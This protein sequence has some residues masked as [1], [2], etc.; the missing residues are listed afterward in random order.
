MN[1][2]QQR[3][4]TALRRMGTGWLLPGSATAELSTLT[5]LHHSLQNTWHDGQWC[6][7]TLLKCLFV[8][9]WKAWFVFPRCVCCTAALSSACVYSVVKRQ[10]ANDRGRTLTALCR[11]GHRVHIYNLKSKLLII[12]P[13]DVLLLSQESLTGAPTGGRGS[14]ATALGHARGAAACNRAS[15]EHSRFIVF[16]AGTAASGRCVCSTAGA[17]LFRPSL[18]HR[19][20]A[21]ALAAASRR[22]RVWCTAIP[23]FCARLCGQRARQQAR[24]A[25]AW[26]A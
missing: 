25:C 13:F 5:A 18:L 14:T 19:R 12:P 2:V 3:S 16:R 26:P 22:R 1:D 7:K 9:Y 6:M 15:F 8:L 21:A 20:P 4:K 17:R 11:R 10:H 24:G 23:S